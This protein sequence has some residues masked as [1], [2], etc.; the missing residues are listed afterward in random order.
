MKKNV[1][2]LFSEFVEAKSFPCIG[3]KVAVSTGEASVF[4][5]GSI[6][7]NTDDQQ[8]LE[9]LYSFIDIYREQGNHYFSAIIAFNDTDNLTE[10]EF[11]KYLWMRLQSLS[12]LDAQ[13][14]PYDLRVSPNPASADFSFSLKQESFYIIGLHPGSS[15]PARQFQYPALVFNPHQQFEKMRETG[16]YDT[17]KKT[18]RKK[19]ILLAGNINPM[20]RDHGTESE[21]WQYSGKNQVQPMSCP[22][23]ALHKN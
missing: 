23:K 17:M 4:A 22:F 21:V 5:A 3:A 14:Y 6:K 15:R 19:D 1:Q 7:I 18:V 8:I 13:N 16:K 10:D 20:L 11:E 9:F 12:N 2:T